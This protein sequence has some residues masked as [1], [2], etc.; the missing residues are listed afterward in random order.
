[1]KRS[2]ILLLLAILV[3]AWSGC[4][5]DGTSGYTTASQ[6]PED[7]RTISIPIWTRGKDVYTR[8][9]EFRLTEAIQKRVQQ[10]TPYRLASREKADSELT[11]ELVQIDRQVL[12]NNPD[13]GRPRQ[14]EIVFTVDFSW[15]DLRT[16]NIL[17]SRKNFRVNST[18]IP[19]APFNEDFFQGNEDVIN[20]IARLV[21]EQMETDW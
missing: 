13:D 8:E 15:K 20:K 3:F 9:V 6:F 5:G 1:M 21:V 17:V 2:F 12:F 4:S 11:G 14:I 16:G 18:Y 7:I 19:P 10:N